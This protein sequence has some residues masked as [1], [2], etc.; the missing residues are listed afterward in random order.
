[1]FFGVMK[2]SLGL[3]RGSSFKI[4]MPMDCSVNPTIIT[5]I[6]QNRLKNGEKTSNFYAIDIVISHEAAVGYHPTMDG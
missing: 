5:D 6:Y 2:Q 3:E 1:M 4:R